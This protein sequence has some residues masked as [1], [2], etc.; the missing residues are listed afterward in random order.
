MDRDLPL[1]H[2]SFPNID[3]VPRIQIYTQTPLPCGFGSPSQG[4]QMQKGTAQLMFDWETEEN[5]FLSSHANY[6]PSDLGKSQ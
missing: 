6:L 4:L 5:K 1:P 3:T 2:A